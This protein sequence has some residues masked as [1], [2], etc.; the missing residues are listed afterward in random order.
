MPPNRRSR[1]SARAVK[2][3]LDP[4]PAAVPGKSASKVAVKGDGAGVGVG[5]HSD[6][7]DLPRKHYRYG[8]N[9]VSTAYD[10]NNGCPTQSSD[11]SMRRRS[12]CPSNWMPNMS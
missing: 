5:A 7:R 6:A 2:A 10:F 11:N 3:S 4:K 9:G 1:L 12:G 8:G